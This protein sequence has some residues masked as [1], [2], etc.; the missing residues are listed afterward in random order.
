MY[1][2]WLRNSFIYL[3]ILVAIVAIV[4]TVFAKGGTSPTEQDLSQFVN[5]AKAERVESV[6]VHG[7]S[8]E[9]KLKSDDVTYKTTL[10]PGDTV[11]QVLEDAGVSQDKQPKVEI[12]RR[13]P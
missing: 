6:K 12:K 13:S 2:R 7:T 10:E 11:R 8:V 3:L 5:E 9:Y 4:F 1:G